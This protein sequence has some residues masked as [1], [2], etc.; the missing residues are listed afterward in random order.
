MEHGQRNEINAVATLVGKILPAFYPS[1][2]FSEGGCIKCTINDSYIIV[3][4]DGSC[5]NSATDQT[6]IA[7]EIKCPFPLEEGSYKPHVYYKIPKYYVP[8]ILSEMAALGTTSLLFLC[9]SKDTT[10][11]MEAYFDNDLW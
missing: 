3:S 5:V 4:P 8:Q 7:V 1:Y 9:Y 6:E 2:K 10:V 11:V